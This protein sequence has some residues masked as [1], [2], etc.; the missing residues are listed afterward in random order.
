MYPS[1][2]GGRQERCKLM[3]LNQRRRLNLVTADH[4]ND[5]KTAVPATNAVPF[6]GVLLNSQG[7]RQPP[8]AA[9]S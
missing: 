4:D 3:V 2:R 8:G 6:V 9:A 1:S 7:S 5:M